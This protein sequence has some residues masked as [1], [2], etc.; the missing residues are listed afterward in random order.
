MTT[1]LTNDQITAGAAVLGL[2]NIKTRRMFAST[3]FDGF[4]REVALMT[5]DKSLL[6]EKADDF[7][8]VDK[9]DEARVYEVVALNASNFDALIALARRAPSPQVA[10]IAEL[11]PLKPMPK[12]HMRLSEAEG[13]EDYPA[14][15]S[16]G[17]T[18]SHCCYCSSMGYESCHHLAE[19]SAGQAGQVAK[20]A[21][22]SE[23][24]VRQLALTHAN[25]ASGGEYYDF[26]QQGLDAFAID[27]MDAVSERAA[28]PADR[29]P[30]SE[31]QIVWETESLAAALAKMD[32]FAITAGTW[33]DSPSPTAQQYWKRACLAQELL[34]K[35]DPNDAVANLDE[36]A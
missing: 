1:T 28:A 21:R 16:A 25:M 22:L 6:A 8:G 23:S 24:A 9:L 36:S 31:K 15:A 4:G 11:P 34:T 19:V 30:R 27:I 14:P 26:T 12:P 3:F 17:Q 5:A 33:R 35:T 7:L 13:S 29:K 18:A 10:D 2:D 32:G 20:G